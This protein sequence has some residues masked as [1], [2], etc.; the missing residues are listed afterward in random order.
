M[1]FYVLFLYP[2]IMPLLFSQSSLTLAERAANSLAGQGWLDWA[3]AAV[4]MALG[5][6]GI[7]A[8]LTGL[9]FALI[10]VERKIAGHFQ[11]R[12]GPMR[13]GPHGIFQTL[14]DTFKLL[15]K[16]DFVPKKADPVLHLLAPFLSMAA[17]VLTLGVLP[18][19]PLMQ[20]A[21]LDIGVLYITAVSGLGVLGILL[22][23][24]S[25]NNKWS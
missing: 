24:W 3:L 7:G 9:G 21:D 16:E 20:V 22:A 23:G 8:L 14:A 5:V 10:Y 4:W 18:Y 11:C 19:S 1:R 2:L 17:T 12:L 25:S 6:A 15:F 13:V